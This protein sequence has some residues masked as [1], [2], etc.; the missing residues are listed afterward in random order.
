MSKDITT[1]LKEAVGE[2]VTQETLD[3]IETLFNESVDKRYHQ[4]REGA[5]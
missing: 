4:G 5:D 3:Q 1:I 2:S